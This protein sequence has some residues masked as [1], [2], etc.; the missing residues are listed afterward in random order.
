LFALALVAAS[1]CA[2]GES[3]VGELVARFR[4]GNEKTCEE[5]GI[6]NIAAH[7]DEREVK[8]SCAAGNEIRISGLEAG[9]YDV[10]IQGLDFKDVVVMDNGALA[11]HVSA[12]VLPGGTTNTPIVNLTNVPAHL[13]ARW[14]FDGGYGTCESVNVAKFRVEAW[15][16]SGSERLHLADIDCLLTG[17]G[18]HYRTVED[19]ERK[20]DGRRFGEVTVQALRPDNTP[21]GT[22]VIFRLD[23]PPG[24][25]Y[26]VKLTV[27][28]TKDI[29]CVAGEKFVLP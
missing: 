12:E 27:N 19:P 17:D 1:G 5:L 13:Y 21:F 15:D 20:I 8:Q 7:V 11:D 29:G 25:G 24:A 9:T 14:T 23:T 16:T 18:E 3:G 22:S 28:C 2:Q 10:K 4:L 26:F 6:V